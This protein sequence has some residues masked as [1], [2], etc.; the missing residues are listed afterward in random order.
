M[1]IELA[2][3]KN[4]NIPESWAL[5]EV[6]KPE[7]DPAKAMKSPRLSPLGG[8]EATGGHKGSGL[9]FMVDILSGILSGEL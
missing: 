6:G 3:R 5:N 8:S 1:K 7:N 4:K 2:L 9:L